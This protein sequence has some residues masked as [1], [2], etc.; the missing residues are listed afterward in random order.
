M[1]SDYFRKKEKSKVA[2]RL[3]EEEL[4][5]VQAEVE[6]NF[7]G[8]IGQSTDLLNIELMDNDQLKEWMSFYGLGLKDDSLGNGYNRN[9]LRRWKSFLRARGEEQT[10]LSVIQ[11]GGELFGYNKYPV[12][13]YYWDNVPA[14]VEGNPIDGYIYV[15]TTHRET[16][17]NNKL[18]KSI[19]PAGY[20]FDV[21][22]TNDSMAIYPYYGDLR[23]GY[24]FV[25]GQQIVGEG[26]SQQGPQRTEYRLYKEDSARYAEVGP[27]YGNFGSMDYERISD[28]TIDEDGFLDTYSAFTLPSGYPEGFDEMGSAEM[29]PMRSLSSDELVS[30]Y[31][32]GIQFDKA[33]LPSLKG[34]G[35][36]SNRSAPIQ[37]INCIDLGS[38]E[39]PLLAKY[40]WFDGKDGFDNFVY[41]PSDTEETVAYG[42]KCWRLSAESGISAIEWDVPSESSAFEPFAI[43]LLCKENIRVGFLIVGQAEEYTTLS[44]SEEWQTLPWISADS[45]GKTCRVS[46]EF[47][48]GGGGECFLDIPDAFVDRRLPVDIAKQSSAFAP[49]ESDITFPINWSFYGLYQQNIDFETLWKIGKERRAGKIETPA[50]EGTHGFVR[51]ADTDGGYTT[52]NLNAV[53]VGTKSTLSIS[54]TLEEPKDIG[55]TRS[56]PSGH[57]FGCS[58]RYEGERRWNTFFFDSSQAEGRTHASFAKGKIE[59]LFTDLFTSEGDGNIVFDVSE[60]KNA[61]QHSI[62]RAMP[63]L[64]DERTVCSGDAYAY[65]PVGTLAAGNDFSVLVSLVMG[66]SGMNSTAAASYVDS[67]CEDG[68]VSKNLSLNADSTGTPLKVGGETGERWFK[69]K[70]AESA[71]SEFLKSPIYSETIL[72]DVVFQNDDLVDHWSFQRLTVAQDGALSDVEGSSCAMNFSSAERVPNGLFGNQDY[73]LNITDSDEVCFT[74]NGSPRYH[75]EMG[76]SKSFAVSFWFKAASIEQD[77]VARIL[78]VKPHRF[79]VK[80]T[81]GVVTVDHGGD[82]EL[83]SQN[84]KAKDGEWNNVFLEYSIVEGKLRLFVNDTFAGETEKTY[85]QTTQSSLLYI[86]KRSGSGMNVEIGQYDEI[87]VWIGDW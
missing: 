46:V 15:V 68:I 25:D 55:V 79:V 8:A 41:S 76:Y 35:S 33:A 30:M 2:E 87:S 84:V 9:A 54:I 43:S 82:D 12:H 58:Y 11:S 47:L 6:A 77:N 80:L 36:F 20:A 26:D 27:T 18:V 45:R 21:V 71:F 29:A 49:L 60:I 64:F 78:M 83:G 65:V 23:L 70:W 17:T 74:D 37:K 81:D 42:R 16:I 34:I 38:G 59:F 63:L 56:V 44:G 28:I 73:C 7:I 24:G 10:L 86:G 50:E 31:G 14:W 1:T 32:A 39:E 57:S 69:A 75:N 66:C 22:F 72:P 67:H 13:L 19:K 5:S 53:P 85:Q 61:D 51:V 40:A 52:G 3:Q 62:D 48:D 4:R